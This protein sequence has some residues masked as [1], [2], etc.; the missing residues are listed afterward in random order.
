MRFAV[1]SL[2]T[3]AMHEIRDLTFPAN[4]AWC[5]L[6]GYTWVAGNRPLDP[7]RP[8]SWSKVRMIQELCKILPGGWA[9]WIDAD[10]AVVRPEWTLESIV[11]DNA[12]MI[13]ASDRNGIN[14]GVFMMRLGM[15]A[16]NFLATVYDRTEYLHHRWW[17]QAA[18][19]HVLDTG[20][21]FRVKHIDKTLINAYPGDFVKGHSAIIH[22][23]SSPKTI[24]IG[25]LT[26]R[27]NH[28]SDSAHIS[29]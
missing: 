4:K 24:R 9:F 18:F 23:P 1:L 7:L 13:V 10:A 8:A 16:W 19:M 27:I 22:V 17:E 21:P 14:T 6:H 2:A 5:D 29:R 12:E 3:D 11:D 25:E 20:Y 28:C 15:M 26:R